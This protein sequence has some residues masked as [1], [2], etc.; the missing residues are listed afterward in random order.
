MTDIQH[1]KELLEAEKKTLTD[2]L[3]AVAQKGSAGGES[4][5]AVQTDIGEDTADRED[6]A[7]S[8]DNFETND[9]TTTSL[10]TQLN[11]VEWALEKIAKGTYGVCEVGGEQI[12]ED[13]LEANPSARTCKKHIDS[14]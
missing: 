2:D 3:G 10:R 14:L 7:A 9:S 12:E 5:D 4:W 13:R 11:E 6:V 8:L 1:Y